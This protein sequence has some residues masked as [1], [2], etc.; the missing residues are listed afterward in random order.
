MECRG[1]SFGG[2]LGFSSSHHDIDASTRIPKTFSPVRGRRELSLLVLYLAARLGSRHRS[3]ISLHFCPKALCWSCG[4]QGLPCPRPL[5]LLARIS[6][7]APPPLADIGWR[8]HYVEAHPTYAEACRRRHASNA[9]VVV[10]QFAG[11]AKDGETVSLS[12]AGPFSSAVPDEIASVAGSKMA[13]AL[14]ALSWNPGAKGAD[15]ISVKTQKLDTF[16]AAQ[17]IAPGSV[18]VMV[19]DVEGFEWPI[20]QGFSIKKWKPKTVIVEIQNMQAR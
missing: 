9:G 3:S 7:H 16:F 2:N 1:K 20:F 14:D 10:H 4:Y 11:G 15:T 18:D 5:L 12:A 17:K 8:G 6:R 13:G 19:V